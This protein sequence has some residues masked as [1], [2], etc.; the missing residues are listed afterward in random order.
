MTPL[1][2]EIKTEFKKNKKK[3]LCTKNNTLDEELLNL[4]LGQIL[5]Y[6]SIYV[7]YVCMYLFIVTF[8][9]STTINAH[10]FVEKIVFCDNTICFTA[11]YGHCLSLLLF[12]FA[13]FVLYNCITAMRIII[14][15]A[16]KGNIR[17]IIVMRNEG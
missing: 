12:Y 8:L 15:N 11:F 7:R 10:Y 14:K 17:L 2:K 6:F 16:E 9:M 4:S 3:E 1:K 5:F 13:T